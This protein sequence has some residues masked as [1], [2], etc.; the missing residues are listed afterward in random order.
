MS[1]RTLGTSLKQVGRQPAFIVVATILLIAAA[2]LGAAAEYLH[3]HFRKLAVPMTRSFA[4]MPPRL[5]KWLQVSIDSGLAHDIQET[6]GTDKYLYRDYV[7]TSLLS[8]QELDALKNKSP[9]EIRELLAP[10]RAKN[11]AAV[12]NVGLTYYTG[13]VDT[14]AHIPERCY[15]ADGYEPTNTN[16][17]H[18][19]ALAGRP[20]S[21]LVRSIT[22]EDATPGRASFRRNVAYVFNCNGEY[23]ND[24]IAVRKR[25]A[26]L[27]ERYGYYTKVEL[28]TLNLAP[29]EANRVMN[30]FLTQALPEFEKSLPD[31][32]QFQPG[33]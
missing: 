2:G 18:W 24:S 21:D 29:D 19:T 23:M 13:L 33:S 6:L 25:L 28:Q 15:I 27:L 32:K 30:D 14:V 20:G 31:W 22:F 12:L 5:G 10:I 1:G 26:N 4:E 11:P 17:T 8:Q 16:D 9:E 7:D 3:L